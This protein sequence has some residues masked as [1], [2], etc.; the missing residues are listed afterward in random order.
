MQPLYAL[1]RHRI[2]TQFLMAYYD[3]G[4]GYEQSLGVQ[5]IEEV[6]EASP[7]EKTPSTA[8]AILL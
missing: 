4:L 5:L 8:S 3:G 1:Q 7:E 6:T 2:M